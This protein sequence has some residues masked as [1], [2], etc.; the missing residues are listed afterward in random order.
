MDIRQRAREV[1]QQGY[2]M[3]LGTVD[4]VGVWVADVIYVFDDSL[5]LYWMSSPNTRHSKALELNG[6]AAGSITV[7][8]TSG[9]GNL[10]L[11]FE[12]VASKLAEL[13][14]EIAKQYLI[15]RNLPVPD[16]PTDILRPGA[17]WYMLKPSSLYLI[18]EKNFGFKR[19][20]VEL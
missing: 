3:S 5:T 20:E 19:Q 6:K 16:K 12:G 14:F 11:Q 9:E 8:T 10:G 4:D 17:S 2:L 15:K 13:D 1:L 18:D 7:S